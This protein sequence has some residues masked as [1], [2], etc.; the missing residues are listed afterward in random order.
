MTGIKF[1]EWDAGKYL[2]PDMDS[3]G[4]YITLI[5]DE[6]TGFITGGNSRNALTWMNV[7]GSSSKGGNRGVPAS[8]RY[9]SPPPPLI[10]LFHYYYILEMELLLN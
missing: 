9:Y 1:T 10:F 8:P 5:Y 6:K 4:F 7:I 2:D 3:L